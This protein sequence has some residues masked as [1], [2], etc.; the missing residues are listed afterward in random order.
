MKKPGIVIHEHKAKVKTG[1][2]PRCYLD[3]RMALWSGRDR[4]ERQIRHSITR[5]GWAK[6]MR[7]LIDHPPGRYKKYI[8]FR[9]GRMIDQGWEEYVDGATRWHPFLV[10]QTSE[11]VEIRNKPYRGLK[12]M[13]KD[14]YG[15]LWRFD[16][17]GRHYYV[18]EVVNATPLKDGTFEHFFIPVHRGLRPITAGGI[19][20]TRQPFTAKNAVA[21]T[22]GLYGFQYRVRKAS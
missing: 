20:G 8:R 4:S 22:F 19:V 1:G 16:I 21:S 2:Y 10:A 11:R 5:Y 15:T 6:Y 12:A 7:W 18:V 13:H 17:Y 14:K 3:E 9:T